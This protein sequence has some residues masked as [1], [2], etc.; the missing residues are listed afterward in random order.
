VVGGLRRPPDSERPG[1]YHS[2]GRRLGFVGPPPS[3]LKAQIDVERQQE[4]ERLMYVALTRAQARLVLPC[5]SK[6]GVAKV[7]NGAYGRINGRLFELG[8]SAS[9]TTWTSERVAAARAD[10]RGP[11]E[12]SRAWTPPA[13]LCADDSAQGTYDVL[14]AGRAGP[15]G[16]SY[17]RMKS[18]R[19]RDEAWDTAASPRTAAD[20]PKTHAT[21][22]EAART[23]GVF[24]HELLERIPLASFAQASTFDAWRVRPDVEGLLDEAMAVHRVPAAQRGHAEQ[25]AWRAFMTPL[26]LPPGDDRVALARVGPS[27][28]R[29][30][31]F[32]FPCVAP[33]PAIAR[34]S[35]DLLFERAGRAYFVDW[36]SDSL[37]SYQ[38]ADVAS[39]AVARYREQ[40]ELYSLAVLKLLGVATEEA[41]EARFGGVIY[42]FLR[43]LDEAGGGLWAARPAWHEVLAW[44]HR[45]GASLPAPPGFG[46]G[47]TP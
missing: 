30:M 9:S 14:R 23:S 4:D 31:R 1:I 38:A 39:C 47:R 13:K 45:F 20:R 19:S 21:V 11:A 44:A 33:V 24:L 43:G 5:V 12:P 3:A 8:R 6:G 46:E 16:T 15:I 29:E 28:V 17:T 40:V 26:A 22:L 42:C 34:G 18:E 7:T 41:Y 2:G 36:K 25:L 27:V 32:A 10:E 37:E 35:L